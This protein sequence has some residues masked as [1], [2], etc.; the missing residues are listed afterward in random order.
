MTTAQILSRTAGA[1]AHH[2]WCRPLL[3]DD[4]IVPGYDGRLTLV[5]AISSAA[6]IDATSWPMLA[7][8]RLRGVWDA[9]V[10]GMSEVTGVWSRQPRHGLDQIGRVLAWERSE[11]STQHDLA[12]ILTTA[13]GVATHGRDSIACPTCLIDPFVVTSCL[14]CRGASVLALHPERWSRVAHLEI[15]R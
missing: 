11:V 14:T 7:S 13:E 5:G 9:L 4:E 2:G 10:L 8:P 1:I 15:A 3:D 12:L 6:G